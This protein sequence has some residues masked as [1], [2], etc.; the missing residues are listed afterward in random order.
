ME[1]GGLMAEAL[2]IFLGNPDVMTTLITFAVTLSISLTA[3]KIYRL[4]KGE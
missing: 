2:K 3:L 1:I 4:S